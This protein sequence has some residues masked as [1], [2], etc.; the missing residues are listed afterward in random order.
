MTSPWHASVITLFPEMFPG[1]LGFSLAGRA[2]EKNIWNMTT[3]PVRDFGLGKHKNVDD[4][5][6]GGGAGMVIMPEVAHNALTH[7]QKNHPNNNPDII[8]MSPRGAPLTQ[9]KVKKIA[10]NPSGCII[11]CG[12]FEGI[13]D[14]VIA[15]WKTS[16]GLQEISIGDY[17]LS[18]GEIGALVLLDACVRTLDGVMGSSTSLDQES[19]DMELLEF[20]H[21]TKPR[22]WLG[23]DVP[24]V[25]LSGHH[26]KIKIW[27]QEQAE[28]ITKERRPDLWER[29]K[30]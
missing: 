10:S 28:Q 27:R 30:K 29:R 1:H 17:I 12:H 23:Y 9:D 25:L 16:H 18:G 2:F 14:R 24:D 20:S 13:D 15:H 21:Y 6:C 11:L 3:I 8:F 19:F 5:P 22:Q 7:A 4:T 26:E